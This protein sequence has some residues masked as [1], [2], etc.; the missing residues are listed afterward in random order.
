VYPVG[1]ATNVLFWITPYTATGSMTATN[2]PPETESASTDD[3]I[4]IGGRVSSDD[5]RLVDAARA[6]AGYRNRNDF[7]V[8]AV[9]KETK[10]VLKR[11]RAT[12]DER[13]SA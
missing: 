2:L 6:V 3:R 5:A 12:D 8:A 9:M 1:D 11:Q 4:L 10:A 7:V 13:R